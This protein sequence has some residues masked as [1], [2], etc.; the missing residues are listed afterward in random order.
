MN[1]FRNL[2]FFMVY[3]CACLKNPY[4]RILLVTLTLINREYFTDVEA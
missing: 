2:A 1:L 3:I 4:I